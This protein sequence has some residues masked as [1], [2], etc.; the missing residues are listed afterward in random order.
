MR[1]TLS[2]PTLL[3]GVHTIE[4]RAKTTTATE[5]VEPLADPNSI[6]APNTK[7]VEAYATIGK[8]SVTIKEVRCIKDDDITE[9]GTP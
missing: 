5:P 6:I 2:A 7:P 4:V 1:L 9:L 3:P 8:G